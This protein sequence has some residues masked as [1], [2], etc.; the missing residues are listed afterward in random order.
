MGWTGWKFVAAI[1]SGMRAIFVLSAWAFSLREKQN[2]KYDNKKKE[3]KKRKKEN[4]WDL[5]SSRNH[6]SSFIHYTFNTKIKRFRESRHDSCNRYR[7]MFAFK[8]RL[9]LSMF[10]D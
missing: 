3:K 2:L 9:I 7:Y 5:G 8:Y 4:S 1:S 10:Y 6:L